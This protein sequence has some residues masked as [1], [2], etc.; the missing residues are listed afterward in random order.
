MRKVYFFLLKRI[1]KPKGEGEDYQYSLKDIIN[2][3]LGRTNYIERNQDK[4][5]DYHHIIYD[6]KKYFEIIL[7]DAYSNFKFLQNFLNFAV[8]IVAKNKKRFK[9]FITYSLTY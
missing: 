7:I 8:G 4:G 5:F 2:L 1:L 3:T 9:K 6:I